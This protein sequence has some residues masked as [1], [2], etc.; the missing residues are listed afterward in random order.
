MLHIALVRN[1]IHPENRDEHNT[2][3]IVGKSLQE[4]IDPI[5]ADWP[6]TEF[7]L[8]VNG[9]VIEKDD[10]VLFYPADGDWVLMMPVIGKGLGDIFKSLLLVA[11][12]AWAGPA[13]MALA[14]TSVATTLSGIYTGLITMVG[15]AIINA[16]IPASQ[17]NSSVNYDPSDLSTSYGWNGSTVTETPGTPVGR[18]YGI[19]SPTLVRLQR[20]ISSS[21]SDQYL[22]LLFSCGSGP[23]DSIDNITIGGNPIANYEDVEYWTRLGTND[24]DVIANFSDTIDDYALSY[25]LDNDG[26]WH[27]Q[28]TNGNAVQGLEVQVQFPNGLYY[29][30]DDASLGSASV[31]INAQYKPASSDIW[32][33]WLTEE[34][35]SAADNA[36]IFRTYRIDNLLAGQ[37]DV[38]MCCTAKSGTTTRFST[39]IYWHQL[40]EIVYDDFCYPNLALL[41][42]R[43]KATDQL[44]GSDPEVKCTVTRSKVW[45][46]NPDSAAYEQKRAGNPFWA[47]CDLLHH[48]EYLK[49]IQTG[50]SEF[51]IEGVSANRFD[52]YKFAECAAY[53][54]ELLPSGKYRFELNLFVEGS[55]TVKEALD[56]ITMVGRGKILPRGTKFSCICDMPQTMSMVFCDANISDKSMS[57]EWQGIETRARSVEVT[58]WNKSK[59]YT[60]DMVPYF[61]AAYNDDNTVPNPTQL[62]YKG[63]T[64]DEHA[65]REAT[66]NGRCNEYKERTKSW[67]ADVC[68]IGCMIGDVVGV[69]TQTSMWGNGGR[70]VSATS[71]SVKLD[72]KV[73]LLAEST[74]KI[75]LTLADDTMVTRTV[76]AVAEDTETDTLV[77]TEAFETIPEKFDLFAVTNELALMR[78]LSIIR[79][80]DQK[81]KI[82]AEQY[83]VE[84][85]DDNLDIPQL[86]YANLSIRNIPIAAS[87]VFPRPANGTANL[88]V[89]FN[90]PR[91]SRVAG[92]KILAN[93]SVVKS[94]GIAASGGNIINVNAS[95]IYT[96]TVN[97]VD[98]FGTT[99]A[100]GSVA[101]KIGIEHIADVD[102]DSLTSYYDNNKLIIA[103]N[104]V[105]DYRTIQYEWRLGSTWANGPQCGRTN[106]PRFAPPSDGMYW[107]A[108]CYGNIY[109]ANPQSVVVSGV[110]LPENILA[111]LDEKAA[112][113]IGTV[114]GGAY[115][116][117]EQDIILLAGATNFDDI[118]DIDAVANLDFCGGAASAGTYQIAE[119]RRIDIGTAALCNVSI[120]Y[121]AVG[122][123]ISDDFDLVADVDSLTSWDGE[124]GQWVSATPQIRT[125]GNDG[126]LGEWKN[127]YSGQYNAR[128]FDFRLVLASTNSEAT[129]KL[130]DY[131]I[132]VDVPDRVESGTHVLIP[133]TGATI[134]YATPF[135]AVPGPNVVILDAE[136]GDQ[137][138]LPKSQQ[139]KTGFFVQ[140]TNGGSGVARYVNWIAKKY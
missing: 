19:V 123:T 76:K 39:R 106:T 28:R 18:T 94:I 40:S 50:L 36:A 72:R 69:Q 22:N 62:T 90:W 53:A 1:P 45:I 55:I 49:N 101:Y 125:A 111:T 115:H 74:Y 10:V 29:T 82:S 64:D 121:D 46:W 113:W 138:V 120:I 38:R 78:I 52:F 11:L 103:C 83:F 26:V 110:V 131:K 4:Y 117:T 24:Q 3:L 35:I 16:I 70:I 100:T 130:Q 23:V 14:H 79:A 57:G 107:V 37:Y 43:I 122:D 96:I 41:G 85:Y 58:F 95:G 88:S 77:I 5:I 128:I 56:Q 12:V 134:N 92:A 71:N 44:S 48:C 27:T 86:N 126:V 54:D 8:S 132:T 87:E 7:I 9:N 104:A 21:G 136:S 20:H 80:N 30:N 60:K 93:G 102:G 59:N 137:L 31:I 112:G 114:T 61:S 33:D 32:I 129:V 65:Y 133:D 97:V 34:I 47:A 25:D 109:S 67:Q 119:S 73:T 13:G 6:K 17:E 135:N 15:G 66:Y 99:I 98:M 81:A 116:D 68:A 105:S 108:A 91:D 51:Y 124:Y 118:P 127:L 63:I 84:I 89:S 139:T 140:I 2:E 42:I 75:Y